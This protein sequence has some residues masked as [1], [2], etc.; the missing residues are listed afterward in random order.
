M[1]PLSLK[2]D[3]LNRRVASLPAE[4][5]AWSRSTSED[6]DLNAHFSQL[7]AI[8]VLVDELIRPQVAAAAAL[9]PAGDPQ[10]FASKSLNVTREIIR[11]QRWWDFFRD[12]L[13]LRH[14]PAH[15]EALWAADTVAWNCHRPVMERAVQA[16]I[17]ESFK[18]REPPLIYC[19][20]EYSPATWVRRS[21]PNDGRSYHL[22]ETLLP[23]PVIEMPWDHLG[24]SWDYLSLHHEVGHDIEADLGLR[25]ALHGALQAA[26]A[27]NGTPQ[28]R[29][30]TWISWTGEV[31]A[32][33]CGLRLAGPAFADSL[34]QLLLLPP[35]AVTTFDP[36]D[37]HPTHY[38]RILMNAAYIRRLGTSQA[39]EAHAT[40]IEQEWK[41]LYGASSGDA[42]LDAL[43]DDVPTVAAAM[44]D[45]ALA[46]LKGK[47]VAELLPFTDADDAKIRQAER[48]FRTGMASPAGLPARH[49]PSAARLAIHELN[50]SA[51]MNQQTVAAI[52]RRV[53]EYIKQN[54]PPGVRGGGPD[55][56]EAFVASF[57]TG[58]MFQP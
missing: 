7:R 44:M 35:Q 41:A 52:H 2:K 42:D 38:V 57:A 24:S 39:L 40:R 15:K 11:A 5:D 36:D 34:M 1:L 49:V 14:V 50:V 12:K 26:L 18:V 20:A 31:F 16:G 27:A 22:G 47:T 32:D 9:D 37:P 51:G 25:M 21:R 13:D 6:L 55:A 17:V 19:S 10:L 48:F 43:L 33:L 23:I 56:H 3:E 45:T 58:R 4:V 8:K 46:A 30:D 53:L 28:S 29:I 54:A